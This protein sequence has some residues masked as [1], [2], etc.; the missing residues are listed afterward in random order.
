MK[1][2][3][4]RKIAVK[5]V[6][7]A[8]AAAELGSG[9]AVFAID[10]AKVDMVATIVAGDGRVVRTVCWKNPGENGLVLQLLSGLRRAGLSVEAVMES[11]GTYGD[12]L[13][14]Q[15]L[16]HGVP[17]YRASGKRTHDAAEGYDGVPSLHDA[18]SAAIIANSCTKV[19]DRYAE[20]EQSN[21]LRVS[22]EP[23]LPLFLRC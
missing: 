5:E 9:R 2:R 11:S 19:N 20:P 15:L 6:D 16:E 17:V 1:K 7:V 4:Y 8:V 12:V 23:S 13:R 10:V 18:T 3:T 22:S 14:H 21:A